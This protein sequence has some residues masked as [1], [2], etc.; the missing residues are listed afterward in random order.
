MTEYVSGSVYHDFIV[1]SGETGVGIAA[2]D[3]KGVY[4]YVVIRWEDYANKGAINQFDLF[5]S[6]EASA[7][8]LRVSEPTPPYSLANY[9]HEQVIETGGAKLVQIVYTSAATGEFIARIRGHTKI[10]IVEDV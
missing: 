8:L 1:N 10:E 7:P 5:T 4:R 3:L 9:E 2:I 6:P